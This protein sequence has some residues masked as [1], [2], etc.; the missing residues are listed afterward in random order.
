MSHI[1]GTASNRLL[2]PPPS[3]RTGWP[4][5]EVAP[6]LPPT[7][8]TGCPWP[9]VTVVTPSYNQARFIEETLRS[10]LL[11]GYP[12][13]EYFVIDGG[14][15]DGS[16]EIIKRYAPFLA[17]WTSERDRG[18]SHAINKGFAWATGDIVA[19]INSDDVYRPGAI[20]AAVE[21][22]LRNPRAG[23][24]YGRASDCDEHGVPMDRYKGRPFSL[25][26]MIRGGTPIAQP[27]AFFDKRVLD[28]AGHLDESLHYTMDYDLW[29][30]LAAAADVVFVDAI[31]SDFRHYPESK[32]GTA[33]L[34][35]LIDIERSLTRAFDE[36]I[37]PA[38]FR[39]RRGEAL[40]RAA[41]K[42]AIETHWRR[43][44]ETEARLAAL[45]ALRRWPPIVFDSTARGELLRAI[46]GATAIDRA[47]AIARGPALPT[48][49]RD[50]AGDHGHGA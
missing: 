37:L 48:A 27:S 44:G 45:R 20:A 8:S 42:V 29:L 43:Q 5:T 16:V 46:V 33:W 38:E 12:R 1:A 11:Q 34:P 19:W 7:T 3:G 18:Q 15:N 31:W 39:A 49:D 47:R 17:R 36:G 35:F 2:P 40:A 30:R 23:L 4:W 10:V 28:K 25:D 6:A 22:F 21:E 13:L 32:S 24:V 50:D 9:R 26:D 14:S 41:L